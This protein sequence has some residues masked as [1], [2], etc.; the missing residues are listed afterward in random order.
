V[1]QGRAAAETAVRLD[2]TLAESHMALAMV[3]EMNW[4]WKSALAQYDEALRLKPDLAEARRRYARLLAEAGHFDEAV[5]NAHRAMQ[6]DPYDPSGPYQLGLTLFIAG[7]PKETVELLEPV[8][9]KRPDDSYA[10]HDLSDAYARL[11]MQA[12]G[13][14]RAEYF[15]RLFDLADRETNLEREMRGDPRIRTPWGDKMHAYF[16][17]LQGNRKAAEPYLE[18]LLEDLRNGAVSPVLVAIVLTAQD[19]KEEAVDLLADAVAVHDPYSVFLRTYPFL[20][21][22][23][24]NLRFQEIVAK[25]GI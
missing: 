2:P 1:K 11:A 16:Y 3:H 12:T 4:E 22:L 18:R 15:R 21:P 6:D 17:S 20:E 7:R 13:A 24:S 19:R 9:A 8:V 14:E 25:V 23:R 5:T 10:I